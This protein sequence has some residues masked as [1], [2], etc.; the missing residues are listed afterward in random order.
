MTIRTGFYISHCGVNIAGQVRVTAVAD[1]THCNAAINA[2]R[3]AKRPAA[4]SIWKKTLPCPPRGG[5]ITPRF[6]MYFFTGGSLLEI[7]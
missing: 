2:V 6:P 5:N 4:A 1:F 3:V 7:T